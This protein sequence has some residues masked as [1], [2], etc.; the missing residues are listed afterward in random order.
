[1]DIN[2]NDL[3]TIMKDHGGID[4]REVQKTKAKILES[5]WAVNVGGYQDLANNHYKV[6]F[7][8]QVKEQEIFIKIDKIAGNEKYYKSTFSGENPIGSV[9][10]RIINEQKL[11]FLDENDIFKVGLTYGVEFRAMD[12]IYEPPQIKNSD[13]LKATLEDVIITQ[14]KLNK[15]QGGFENL[16]Y[17]LVNQEE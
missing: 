17:Q 9:A 2:Y 6:H 11:E 8:S 5:N 7:F 12:D 3:V 10:R 15:L 14:R 4:N 1:M 16:L 13:D